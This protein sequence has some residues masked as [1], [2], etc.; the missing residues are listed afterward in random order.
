MV[1]GGPGRKKAAQAESAEAGAAGARIKP[2]AKTKNAV[3]AETAEKNPRGRNTLIVDLGRTGR[4][5][6]QRERGFVGIGVHA[7]KPL[8]DA[9]FPTRTSVISVERFRADV[10]I[11][12]IDFHF[13]SERRQYAVK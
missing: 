10:V 7:G 9:E 3:V 5:A 6:K 8:R 11:V 4:A 2:A 1:V 13:E 12:R